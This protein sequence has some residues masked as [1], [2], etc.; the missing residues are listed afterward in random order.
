MTDANNKNNHSKPL[1][2]RYWPTWLGMGVLWL[3]VQLPWKWQ[4]WLGK[5]LGLLLFYT[6][7]QR[8]YICCVNLELAFPDQT[9]TAR[10]ALNR[11]HFISLG[12]GLLETALSWWG[13]SSTLKQLVTL[14][15]LANLAEAQQSGGVILLSAHFTSLEMGGRLLAPYLPLHVVYRPHQNAVIEQLVA[16]LRAKR[17][18]KAISRD[19]I[20]TM[21]HSLKQGYAVWYAQDQHFD[22]KN[23][24]FAPFFQVEAATNTATSRIATLGNAKVVPFFTFR[25]ENGYKLRF[26]PALQDFPTESVHTDT[27]RINRIIEQQ[28]QA[29]PAQYLW[30]HRR[31]KTSP[32]GN[33]RYQNHQRDYPNSRC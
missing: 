29:Y 8:R 19:N 14:E 26:L 4:M 9:P 31:F 6:L 22:Q 12:R 32:E 17:Y 27:V 11:Q 1:H 2:P 5:Q 23:S 25:T 10:Q 21:L 33:N 16:K 20:R 18:G 28:V 7:K 24:V 15:G 13:R 3:T 30:T